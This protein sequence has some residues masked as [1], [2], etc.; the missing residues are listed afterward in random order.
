MPTPDENVAKLKGRYITYVC[1][2]DDPQAW[3]KDNP[4]RTNQLAGVEIV[5]M[6]VGDCVAYAEELETHVE[7]GVM[8]EAKKKHRAF[9]A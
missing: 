8:R 2:I 6:A 9:Y 7:G 4:M 3:S 5:T 1:R